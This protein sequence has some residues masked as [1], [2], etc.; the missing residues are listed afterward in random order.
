MADRRRPVAR[1]EALAT[2]LFESIVPA[3]ELMTV[4]LGLR[5]G[6][7][8]GLR[9]L[10]D[11]TAA[12][13]ALE[14][15]ASHRYVREWL[16]QQATAGIVDVAAEGGAASRRYALSP[17]HAEVLLDPE[18][19]FAMAGVSAFLSGMAETSDAV[20]ADF[21]SGEGVAYADFGAWGRHAISSLN[22]PAFTITL[23]DWLA[24]LPDIDDRLRTRAAVVIDAGC[25][26]GWST[27]A[28]ARR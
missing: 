14:C 13:L 11:A 3:M 10:G 9:R 24:Q 18:S 19:P 8:S 12:E 6:L 20:V 2:R 15:G 21:G 25:G 28:L 4:E 26:T 16:E 5:R 27:I 1:A 7:Y 23:G 17:A 22:R